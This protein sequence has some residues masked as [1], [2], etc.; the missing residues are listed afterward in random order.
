MTRDLT[1]PVVRNEEKNE[2]HDSD[3]FA[4]FFNGFE[5]GF[6]GM[7][8]REQIGSTRYGGG[9]AN[10]PLT[11]SKP[12]YQLYGLW[13]AVIERRHRAFARRSFVGYLR[14]V[15][16]DTKL[17]SKGF[18]EIFESLGGRVPTYIIP[19]HIRGLRTE[20][21]TDAHAYQKAYAIN[22]LMRVKK[23]R[24]EF[25]ASMARQVQEWLD[26]PVDERKHK[27]PLSPRQ[28]DCL[29]WGPIYL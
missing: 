23:F 6:Y 14:H 11:D 8:S 9:T 17:T 5:K 24:S 22:E 4:T 2:Y 18:R 29:R 1:R 20:S 3:F 27:T 16:A 26:T 25:R 21:G 12:I 10:L 19:N 28:M 15:T 7:F 13:Q